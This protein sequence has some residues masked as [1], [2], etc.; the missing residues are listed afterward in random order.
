MALGAKWLSIGKVL[1]RV[2]ELREEI[3]VFL[4]EECMHEIGGKFSDERFLMKVAYLSDIFGKLK[5][6]NIHLL[7]LFKEIQIPLRI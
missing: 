6:L 5:D 2:F 7:H 3:W 4:E 1:S